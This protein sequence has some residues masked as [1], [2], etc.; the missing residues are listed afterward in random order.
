MLKNIKTTSIDAKFLQLLLLF[1]LISLGIALRLFDLTDQ[2]IDFHS[3]RQLRGAIIARGMYYE[4]D[5]FLDDDLRDM[6]IR[7]WN[8]TGQ[9]EPS[10]LERLVALTYMLIGEEKF[11]IA[12]IYNTIFWIIGGFV[13]FKLTQRMAIN[14]LKFEL[15]KR[16][17]IANW[18]ALLALAYY[19]VLP[20]SVQASRSFQP[21]P[22]MV[23]GITITAFFAYRWSE[24]RIW[25]WALLSGLLAGFT[26]LT[27]AVSGFTV[28]G[29]LIAL[30]IYAYYSDEKLGE[31]RFKSIWKAIRS[32]QVWLMA[33]LTILPTAFYYLS[34]GDRAGE[35]FSTWTIALSHLLL[36]PW[37]YARW[38]NLVRTLVGI[39][40]LI[41]AAVSI[42][43]A[44]KRNRALLIGLWGGYIVYGLFLPY[45]MYTHNYYHLQLVS[46]IAIS[47]TPVSTKLIQ[48]ILQTKILFQYFVAA[49]I[50]IFIML[51][52]WIALQPLYGQNYRNEPLYWQEIASYLPEDGK[53]IAL[54]Q[55][56]GYRL[57]YY[58]WRKV[59]LWPNQGEKNLSKLRNSEK[60]PYEYFGKKTDGVRYF[61]VTSFNQFEKQ[62]TLQEI[63]YENYPLIAENTGFLIFDLKQ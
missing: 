5:L 51:S 6:A 59:I 49:G 33:G 22:L 29:L 17:L 42:I 47:L 60:D 16:E 9:Y 63:L 11:W 28:T 23:T 56:Y 20:F 15:P 57:M 38:L 39:I 13:L 18:S 27:K 24:T 43:I 26:I 7:F 2:P 4:M 35:Y 62:P 31:L 1:I 10:I 34:R 50:I 54:T 53:I 19:L 52:S 44:K 25:K 30:T 3:T 37:L 32:P 12:R 48:K 55:D 36:E 58:G 41:I 21:D 45:Q 61:L 14:S 40:P 8:S 46:I